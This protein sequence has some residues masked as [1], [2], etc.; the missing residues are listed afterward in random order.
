MW[1]T[2]LIICDL[3]AVSLPHNQRGKDSNQ[4]PFPTI[5]GEDLCENKSQ[6][7]EQNKAAEKPSKVEVFLSGVNAVPTMQRLL[8]YRT[9]TEPLA[10]VHCYD[11]HVQRGLNP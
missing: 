11:L 6:I 8:L 10:N 2:G 3:S 5:H 9:M 7:N 1:N 4:L